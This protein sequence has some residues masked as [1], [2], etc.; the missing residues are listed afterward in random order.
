MEKNWQKIRAT[1]DR[2][3]GE[4]ADKMPLARDRPGEALR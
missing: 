1:P 2:V 3:T 4:S